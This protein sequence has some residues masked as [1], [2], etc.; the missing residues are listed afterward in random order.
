ML[1]FVTVAVNYSSLLREHQV[2]LKRDNYM[3]P[4][5]ESRCLTPE[6]EEGQINIPINTHHRYQPLMS[7]NLNL[8]QQE[9]PQNSQKT[10]KDRRTYVSPSTNSMFNYIEKC[11]FIY[12]FGSL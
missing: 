12:L 8:I 3:E 2:P 10:L 7:T 4:R 11:I 1:N 6:Y 5:L 9:E